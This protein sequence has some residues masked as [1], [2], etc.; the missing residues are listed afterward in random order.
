MFLCSQQW[1]GLAYIEEWVNL[2]Q[3]LL[4]MTPGNDIIQKMKASQ[5]QI[6]ERNSSLKW[7]GL[8]YL[9]S[10]YIYSKMFWLDQSREST[11]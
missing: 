1:N 9:K 7:N 11:S 10:E 5:F 6:S 8:A 3:I 2:L 4:R